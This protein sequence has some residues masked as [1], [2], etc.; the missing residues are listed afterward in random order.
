M[1][2]EQTLN[3]QNAFPLVGQF[4]DKARICGISHQRLNDPGSGLRAC[5]LDDAV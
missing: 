3:L 2:T 5:S 1:N 4:E